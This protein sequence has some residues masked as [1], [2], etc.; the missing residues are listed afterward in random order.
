VHK[1]RAVRPACPI[2]LV[3]N[4][5]YQNS[6]LVAHTYSRSTRSNQA[7]DAAYQ[8]MKKAGVERLYY[9]PGDRLLGDDGE[10]TVDGTHPTDL[11]FLRIAQAIEPVLRSA[12]D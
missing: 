3:E 5:T 6:F 12:L 7:L 8:R 10:A 4:I 11:G 2:I 1:L 9:L